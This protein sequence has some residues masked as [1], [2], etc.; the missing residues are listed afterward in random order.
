MF[1]HKL[2]DEYKYALCCNTKRPFKGDPKSL[3]N[4][5]FHGIGQYSSYQ[6]GLLKDTSV[7]GDAEA[8]AR[9]DEIVAREMESLKD[10]ESFAAT[11]HDCSV[12]P[13]RILKNYE[14]KTKE[15]YL[16]EKSVQSGLTP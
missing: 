1:S 12:K 8:I 15:Q 2:S 4:K 10:G 6:F 14:Q 9:A 11:L 5:F 16:A 13:S 7:M 3:G